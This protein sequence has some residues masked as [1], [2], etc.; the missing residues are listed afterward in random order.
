MNKLFVAAALPCLI[1]LSACQQREGEPSRDMPAGRSETQ[2]DGAP[3]TST[4]GRG[5]GELESPG[6][7][8]GAQ[9]QQQ[10]QQQ[11]VDA[12][13]KDISAD[14][15]L[16]SVVN[17]VQLIPGPQ[18][19]LVLSGRVPTAEMRQKLEDHAKKHAQG[20]KVDNQITVDPNAGQQQQGGAMQGGAQPQG[21]TQ[22][23]AQQGGDY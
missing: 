5:E 4:P 3:A 17:E 22:E 9:Q 8:G 23:G 19:D 2:P 15:T 16:A 11:M 10:Q 1:G 6:A 14:P 20:K 18:G 13:K 12:F 21:D 7:A